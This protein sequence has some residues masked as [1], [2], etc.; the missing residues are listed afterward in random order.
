MNTELQRARRRQMFVFVL[1]CGGML[2]L[3]GRLYYWQVLSGP[4]LARLATNEHTKNLPLKA[5][6]GLIFDAQGH[7][8]VTNVIRDDVYIEPRQ[9]RIDFEHDD[10]AHDKWVSLMHSLHQ[11]LPYLSEDTLI[12][13]F[14]SDAW[15]LRINRQPI[16]PAQ[17]EQLRSMRLPDVFL[18]ARPV[19]S[20]PGGDLAAQVLGYVDS[21][22]TGQYG[23]EGKYNAQLAGK[24]GSITAETDLN[25]NPLTVGASS[26]QA[27]VPGANM[28]LTIDSTIQYM[29]QTALVDTIK[30]LQAQSGSVVVLNARTGAVVAMAGA[31]SFDPNHYSDY[32]S[33]TGCVNSASVYFNPVL[34][35]TYEPGSTMKSV[36]M[37]AGLDQGLIT[38]DT[39]FTDNGTISFPDANPV[40]NWNFNAYGVETMTQVLEHSANVGTAYVAHDILGPNRYYPYVQRFGFGQAYNIDGPEQVGTYRTNTSNGWYPTDLTRQAFGQSISTTAFQMAMVYE[41]IANGGV[42]MKPYLVQSMNDNGHVTTTHPQIQRRVISAETAKL[43]SGMLV[44]AANYNKQATF[45]GYSIAVKTGTATTQGLDA[46]QTEASMVGFLPA[47]NPQF[48][49]LVKIDRPSA[50]IAGGTAIFGG[51][52]AAPLW[53]SI[54]EQLMWRYNVPPDLMNFDKRSLGT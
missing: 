2:L 54:A 44:S 23:I 11:V 4:R 39:S 6:R 31:P 15:T 48:V 21:D 41:V 24:A 50:T 3:L 29:A 38:P 12:N 52:A 36:T 18:Q 25:G 53:K 49:I 26:G 42:M 28:T 17:S 20:Y 33:Q 43:L 9:F 19:R 1:V 10:N 30:K 8:L 51:T 47:S 46:S 40:A 5:P 16:E 22:A 32:A 45:P 14:D 13:K 7:L 37:A 34:Y 27:P 35:C